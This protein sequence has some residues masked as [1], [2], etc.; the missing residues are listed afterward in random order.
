MS[1]CQTVSVIEGYKQGW[2]KKSESHMAGPQ[3]ADSKN[4]ASSRICKMLFSL[5]VIQEIADKKVEYFARWRL[6]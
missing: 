6:K 3:A 1:I 2:T 5:E 4:V